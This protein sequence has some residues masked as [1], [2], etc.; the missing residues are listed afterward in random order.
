M[1]YLVELP[2][3]AKEIAMIRRLAVPVVSLALLLA[4]CAK[5]PATDSAPAGKAEPATSAAQ[6][7]AA[8][9]G[10]IGRA[11]RRERV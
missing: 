1:R 4:G 3:L 2:D 9:K 8:A 10:K 5:P 7:P 11:S 6:P